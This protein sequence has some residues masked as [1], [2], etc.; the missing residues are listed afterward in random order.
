MQALR[1][2]LFSFAEGL[3]R[4][5]EIYGASRRLAE[6]EVAQLGQ[7]RWDEVPVHTV[8]QVQILPSALNSMIMYYFTNT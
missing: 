4:G 3:S 5:V 8:S 7:R 6:A 2:V 1:V